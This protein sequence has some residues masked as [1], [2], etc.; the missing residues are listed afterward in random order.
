MAGKA[1]YRHVRELAELA[2]LREPRAPPMNTQLHLR[3]QAMANRSQFAQANHGRP[4][5]ATFTQPVAAERGI[6][7]TAQPVRNLPE[8]ARVA[9]ESARN[10]RPEN[11]PA[12][13]QINKMGPPRTA[14]HQPEPVYPETNRPQ[15]KSGQPMHSQAKPG[16]PTRPQ[17]T[18]SRRATMS[19]RRSQI[20]PRQCGRN[21]IVR[22]RRIPSLGAARLLA[23]CQRIRSRCTRSLD[24]RLRRGQ[25]LRA[26]R[27]RGRRIRSR[28]H[29]SRLRITRTSISRAVLVLL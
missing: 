22:S 5:Q 4:A 18:W 1:V 13:T 20:V 11:Q 12:Q 23:S 14:E 17:R 9:P 2:V 28:R 26:L 7:P 8:S 25:S 6:H 29:T 24:A 21:R 10:A 19:R 15:Q 16:E 3:Q 27:Q